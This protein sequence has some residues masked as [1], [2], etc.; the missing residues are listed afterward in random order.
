MI[1]TLLHA[2]ALRRLGEADHT[3]TDAAF[4]RFLAVV[5]E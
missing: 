2:L 5:R 1:A 4:E 3:L